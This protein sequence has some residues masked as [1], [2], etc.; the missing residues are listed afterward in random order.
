MEGRL[1]PVQAGPQSIL[2]RAGQV[3]SGPSE[4][5]VPEIPSQSFG[6]KTGNRLGVKKRVRRGEQAHPTAS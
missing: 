6:R 3:A 5:N 1:D 2:R 4:H